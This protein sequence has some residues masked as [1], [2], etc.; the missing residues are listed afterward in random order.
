[1]IT[2]ILG[3]FLLVWCLYNRFQ[4]D[5]GREKVQLSLFFGTCPVQYQQFFLTTFFAS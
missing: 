4:E 5:L 3:G 2:W 1:M